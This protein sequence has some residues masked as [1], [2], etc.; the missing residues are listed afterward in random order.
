MTRAELAAA[1]AEPALER[2]GLWKAMVDRQ[3]DAGGPGWSMVVMLEA[4]GP[5]HA[6]VSLLA[7]LATAA[8]A[9]G[10]PLVATAAPPLFGYDALSLTTD[11]HDWKA[12]DVDDQ[13]RWQA[14]RRSV[15]AQ[16]IGL[17]APRMLLRL[18][19][20]KATDPLE[21]FA[22][23]EIAGTDPARSLLW[24]HP[25]AACALLAGLAFRDSGWQMDLDA[26]LDVE[27]LP[28]WVYTCRWL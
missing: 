16:W 17:V 27:D 19:Y 3:R 12:L 24:G 1:A 22:F 7:S 9:T 11:H 21:R 8:A 13:S 5:S 2:S 10:A 4:F 6:D 18:P 26:Q 28:A 15:L 25:G 23:D 14:L 20:G